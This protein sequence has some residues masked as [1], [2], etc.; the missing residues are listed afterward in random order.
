M[1][2][3]G[4]RGCLLLCAVDDSCN[5]LKW[6]GEPDTACACTGC[7]W[8][9]S[10]KGSWGQRADVVDYINYNMHDYDNYFIFFLFVE[11]NCTKH[12]VMQC[13]NVEC[14]KTSYLKCQPNLKLN[15]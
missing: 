8:L 10:H 12:G 11:N 6:H 4:P 14:K 9:H 5:C 15:K 1:L 2:L 7:T 3:I 13:F